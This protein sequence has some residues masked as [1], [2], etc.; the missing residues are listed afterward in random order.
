M[1]S[2]R[3]IMGSKSLVDEVVVVREGC[4]VGSGYSRSVLI[5]G[6]NSGH[7]AW[8]GHS[9]GRKGCQDDGKEAHC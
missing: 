8:S 2:A 4:A 5:G 7:I 9:N 3:N 1:A 6:D